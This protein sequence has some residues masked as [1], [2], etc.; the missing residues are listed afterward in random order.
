MQ[1]YIGHCGKSM[2]N[3]ISFYFANYFDWIIMNNKIIKKNENPRHIYL[4]L[5]YIQKYIKEI[6]N[7][8]N[9]FILITG[10]SDYSP[11]INFINEYNEIIKLP[12]LKK[13]YAE[14]NFSDHP[15]MFSLCVG[16]ATHTVEYENNLLLLN[17]SVNIENKINKV[18]CCWRPRF[19]NV[20][21]SQFIERGNLT[22]FIHKYPNIFDIYEDLSEIEF[23]TKLSNYKWC[24]CPLGNGID[25]AP[26]ILECFFLKTI[27]IVRRNSNVYELYKDYPV[28]WVDNFLDILNMNLTLTYNEFIDWDSIIESFT[29]ETWFNKIIDVTS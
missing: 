26:K 29:C 3:N 18:F 24:L 23:Q 4:K 25:C 17:K 13:W 8:E 12:N 1:K 16:F 21:G 15:K 9:D 6:I 19:T 14:N 11:Q 28:I 2:Q 27:P 22:E 20:C 5:D 10:C 7:I